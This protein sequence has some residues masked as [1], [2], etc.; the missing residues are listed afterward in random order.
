MSKERHEVAGVSEADACNLGVSRRVAQFVQRTRHRPGTFWQQANLLG[1]DEGAAA[2]GHL[3]ARVALVPARGQ[4]YARGDG[5]GRCESQPK[6]VSKRSASSVDD[7]IAHPPRDAG[8]DRHGHRDAGIGAWRVG[9]LSRPYDRVALLEKQRIAVNGRR[10]RIV[11]CGDGL[12]GYIEHPVHQEL[13]TAIGDVVDQ[14]AVSAR[15]VVRTKAHPFDLIV[16]LAPHIA[17]RLVES[18]DHPIARVGGVEFVTRDA[19]HALVGACL[20]EG[21]TGS[22]RFDLAG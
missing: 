9:V 12:R 10:A 4:C 8:R 21:R 1:I 14:P 3:D 16:D 13:A 15:S 7:F 20:A 11:D 17:R 19:T 5:A 6:R 18:D 2:G 22:E